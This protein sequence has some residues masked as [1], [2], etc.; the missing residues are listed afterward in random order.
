MKIGKKR[1]CE[2]I[3]W[4]FFFVVRTISPR[5]CRIKRFLSVNETTTYNFMDASIFHCV[6]NENEN[7]CHCRMSEHTTSWGVRST[8]S[9]NWKLCCLLFSFFFCY[10][11]DLIALFVVCFQ[12]TLTGSK[13]IDTSTL[14]R[15][16]KS[17]TRRKAENTC[18]Q[19]VNRIIFTVCRLN[20][21]SALN[22][23]LMKL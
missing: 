17:E 5:L 9:P 2:W 22:R 15:H 1:A 10:L 19:R 23:N 20:K 4:P 3:H 6:T 21:N 14:F 7:V 8:F 18:T 11:V 12:R 16:R 13:I